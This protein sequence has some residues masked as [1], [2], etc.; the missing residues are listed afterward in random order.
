[1]QTTLTIND[2]LWHEAIKWADTQDKNELIALALTEFIENHR[3]AET[4]HALLETR[5][6][7]KHGRY[8]QET[9]DEHIKEMFD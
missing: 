9:I 6:D 7:M 5:E 4:E 1:M 8:S 2:N 3:D